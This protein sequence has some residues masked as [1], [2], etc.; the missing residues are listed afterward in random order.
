[1][2]DEITDDE[3]EYDDWADNLSTEYIPEDRYG[4]FVNRI[5]E[6]YANPV[7]DGELILDTND[8]GEYVLILELEDG[9]YEKF[10]SV[11]AFDDA[12]EDWTYENSA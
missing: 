7:W 3:A 6:W 8:N 5:D 4:D 11:K 2:I 9:T 12:I 10:N 1:M